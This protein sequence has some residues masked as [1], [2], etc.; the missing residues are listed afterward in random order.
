VEILALGEHTAGT[1]EQIIGPEF[2]V[3][4]AAVQHHLA[5]FK[6]NGWVDIR[7]EMSERW[8]RLEPEAI[9]E[10]VEEVR[11]LLELWNQ[12]YGAIEQR[13]IPIPRTASQ[14]SKK[15]RR[16]HGMDPDDPWIRGWADDLHAPIDNGGGEPP[17]VSPGYA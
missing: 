11:T 2:G 3:T 12:R 8:Y 13:D 6:R 16:G 5:Y 15:G 17:R 4:R 7:P 10:L 1:I 14:S 9:P